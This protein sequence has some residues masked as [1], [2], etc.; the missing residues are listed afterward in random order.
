MKR[1]A[2][3]PSMFSG[4]R[5]ND[6]VMYNFSQLYPSDL[7]RHPSSVTQATSLLSGA[8]P[9]FAD[10][11]NS[12]QRLS[13]SKQKSCEYQNSVIFDPSA[14]SQVQISKPHEAT[15]SSLQSIN[16]LRSQIKLG[17]GTIVEQ[18][19][20]KQLSPELSRLQLTN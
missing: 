9:T 3:K 13:P 12:V 11:T 6:K 17:L 10:H 1:S 7:S 19:S 8:S 4:L 20:V 18:P 15:L 2:S 5:P 16:T 14:V